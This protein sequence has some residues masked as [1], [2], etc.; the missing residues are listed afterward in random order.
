MNTEYNL[1]SETLNEFLNTAKFENIES[2]LNAFAYRERVHVK[3]NERK[4][5]DK[6]I[7]NYLEKK[8][9]DFI[10]KALD[11]SWIQNI[12]THSPNFDPQKLRRGFTKEYDS[13]S[14][15]AATE[16]AEFF[17]MSSSELADYS[18]LSLEG[19]NKDKLL[20]HALN[21][22]TSLLLIE[23]DGSK[24]ARLLVS[25]NDHGDLNIYPMYRFDK[26][27]NNKD[28]KPVL[29]DYLKD[30]KKFLGLNSQRHLKD[31]TNKPRSVFDMPAY[32]DSIVGIL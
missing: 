1:H 12:K 15:K 7:L 10:I 29:L 22:H 17:S 30:Y 4:L 2:L 26:S 20:N 31:P 5:I 23:R 24:L 25:V 3:G 28:I 11:K 21:A 27:I 19:A 6:V 18:C 32:Y 14:I 13:I 16:P 8:S 9:N